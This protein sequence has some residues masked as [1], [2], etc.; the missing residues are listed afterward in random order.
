MCG[1]RLTAWGACGGDRQGMQGS[2]RQAGHG[3]SGSNPLQQPFAARDAAAGERR[4]R[5]GVAQVPAAIMQETP[6]DESSAKWIPDQVPSRPPGACWHGC[7]LARVRRRQMRCGAVGRVPL[8]AWPA[9]MPGAE[10]GAEGAHGCVKGADRARAGGL[11]A[12]RSPVAG[13]ACRSVSS[14]RRGSTSSTGATTAAPAAA[15]SAGLAPPPVPRAHRRRLQQGPRGM[16]HGLARR[17]PCCHGLVRA[18]A[19]LA[20]WPAPPRGSWL[21]PAARQRQST[22]GLVALRPGCSSPPVPD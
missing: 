15:S 7:A 14:A 1:M 18:R 4:R 16:A 10:A 9:G 3:N 2:G 22:C 5:R 12:R 13:R 20:A 17:R 21:L 19:A 8:L 6:L 11:R